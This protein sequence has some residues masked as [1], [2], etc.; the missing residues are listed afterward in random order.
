MA[1][2]LKNRR[3]AV[4]EQG[5]RLLKKYEMSI[6]LGAAVAVNCFPSRQPAVFGNTMADRKT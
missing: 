1:K 3:T 4:V 5:K 6:Q 2:R